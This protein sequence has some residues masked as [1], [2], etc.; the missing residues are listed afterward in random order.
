M[1]L[2][3]EKEGHVKQL[4]ILKVWA[5]A[6]CER[7]RNQWRREGKDRGAPTESSRSSSEMNVPHTGDLS[8]ARYALNSPKDCRTTDAAHFVLCCQSLLRWIK[9]N[10][11]SAGTCFSS[12]SGRSEI[13][14]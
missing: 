4:R 12:E 3:I 14:V 5:F 8:M 9:I 11:R 1:A 2:L 10:G 6:A 13:F 7:W